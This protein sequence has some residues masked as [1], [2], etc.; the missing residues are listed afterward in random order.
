MG[1]STTKQ[2]VENKQEIQK[3]FIDNKIN[4]IND[5]QNK[6]IS[7]YKAES[8]ELVKIED[9]VNLREIILITEKAKSQLNRM[10]KCL[11]KPDL[12]GIVVKLKNYELVKIM[13][14]EQMTCGDLIILIRSII[15]DVPN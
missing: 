9:N 6:V 12:I 10:D 8:N 13:E 7:D 14:L 1:N 3:I 5:L 15:Y 4:K 11:T 2:K